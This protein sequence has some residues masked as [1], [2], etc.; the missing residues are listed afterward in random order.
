MYAVV[1]VE[2]TGFGYRGADRIVEVAVVRLDPDGRPQDAW[3]TLLNPG[4]DVG[5]SRIHGIQNADVV[6]APTFADVA[7]RLVELLR[8]RIVVAHNLRFD[9]AFL[10]AE[11]A[12]TGTSVPLDH[13]PGL[14]TMELARAYL[15]HTRKFTLEDCC[16][17]VGIPLTDAHSALADAY[18]TS[19]L[20]AHLLR[21]VG[22]PPPWATAAT[23]AA[24]IPW[25]R[26]PVGDVTPVT[27]SR[28]VAP[29]GRSG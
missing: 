1:D 26:L 29:A 4:R 10:Q 6:G 27:R 11:Y 3:C 21:I 14:C 17:S 13:T 7:G 5:P 15:P 12:R 25:P 9:L 22:S 24:R 28:G 18:A 23:A 19:D 2:T 8:G 20:L 16:R